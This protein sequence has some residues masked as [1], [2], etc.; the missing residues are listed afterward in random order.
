MQSATTCWWRRVRRDG[1]WARN[2]LQTGAMAAASG[3]GYYS[4][5]EF[6][7]APFESVRGELLELGRACV[8]KA[9]RNQTVLAL[10]W[11]G[12]AEYAARRDARYLTGCSSLTSRVA[13]EGREA[14]AVLAERH[15]VEPRWRTEPMA[16][17]S[18]HDAGAE[19]GVRRVEKRVR[20]GAS[21]GWG[22]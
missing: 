15:W 7:F 17:W 18:C 6:D 4:A 9:H 12:I 8:D 16:G 21:S 10:L 20:C 19:A 5:R 1:W 2:R 11:R 13:A 3:L 14:W 22:R